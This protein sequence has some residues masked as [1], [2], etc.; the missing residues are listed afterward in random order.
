[1]YCFII[2]YMVLIQIDINKD[3][4]KK[5]KMY[6]IINDCNNKQEGIIKIL[7]EKL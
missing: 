2:D 1:M 6:S 4:D 3:L 5:L 7:E